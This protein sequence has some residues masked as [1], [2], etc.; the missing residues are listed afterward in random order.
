MGACL[1]HCFLYIYLQPALNM[2]GSVKFTLLLKVIGVTGMDLALLSITLS[3][4]SKPE[5]IKC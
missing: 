3:S 4:W 1:P 2:S 5:Y